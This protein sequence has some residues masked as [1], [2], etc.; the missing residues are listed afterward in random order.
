VIIRWRVILFVKTFKR[1]LA[2]KKLA[3]FLAAV[4]KVSTQYKVKKVIRR[5]FSKVKFMQRFVRGFLECN[6]ER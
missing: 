6:R 4:R 5:L 2:V 3:L 1:R